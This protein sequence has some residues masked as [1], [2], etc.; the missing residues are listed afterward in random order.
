[1][2]KSRAVV[3]LVAIVRERTD[4]I[5]VPIAASR[6]LRV[7]LELLREVEQFVLVL[8]ERDRDRTVVRGA[9]TLNFSALY[10]S[11]YALE[12]SGTSGDAWD[13]DL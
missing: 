4:E 10:G 9:R 2:R 13:V 1:M 5:A 6:V 11:L 3:T 7:G 12:R 8:A